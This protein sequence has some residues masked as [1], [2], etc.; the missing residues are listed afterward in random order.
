MF[1]HLIEMNIGYW[2]EQVTD[3]LPVPIENTA[4][5]EQIEQQLALIEDFQ[6]ITMTRHYK[7]VSQCRICG[8]PNGNAE[9]TFA[10][11]GKILS[12]PEGLAHYIKDHRVLVPKL[13]DLHSI[14]RS[15]K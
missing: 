11:R 14:I 13:L 9:Y 8:C 15:M 10:K 4:T 3:D 1:S 2:K 12:I 7:G 5:D 6:A